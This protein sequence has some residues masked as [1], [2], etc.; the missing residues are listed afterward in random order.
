MPLKYPPWT[1]PLCSMSGSPSPILPCKIVSQSFR[2]KTSKGIWFNGLIQC[3][4]I[5]Y[6][7][8]HLQ[9]PLPHT[10]LDPYMIEPTLRR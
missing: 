2:I 1:E 6:L 4:H 5:L 9:F 10:L 7:F 8:R 3:S